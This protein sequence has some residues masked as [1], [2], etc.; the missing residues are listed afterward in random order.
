MGLDNAYGIGS[1]RP[2]VCTSSSRPGSPFDGQ[3]IYETDTNVLSIYDGSSWVTVGDTDFT[4]FS[5]WTAW[6][7][8]V[9]ATSG[10][11]TSVS[12]SGRYKQIG[13]TV[14]GSIK[15]NIVTNGT[16]AQAIAFTPPV[17]PLTTLGT[18]FAVGVARENVLTG[19]LSQIFMSGTTLVIIR[20]DNVYPGAT[21]AGFQ[22]TFTYE[23]A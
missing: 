2:G 10:T 1:L 14:F 17:T 16:A 8:T 13:K 12:G 11:F 7:P 18:D 3:V 15:I 21:G 6:T 9:T 19:N 23:A 5:A 22:G 4:P 20:Y